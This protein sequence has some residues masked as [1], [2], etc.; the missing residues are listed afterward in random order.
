[1]DKHAIY[2]H[3]GLGGTS[4]I[5]RQCALILVDFVN[6]FVDVDQ[7][8]GPHIQAAADQTVALLAYFR[9]QGLPIVHTRV[10]FSSDGADVNIFALR[11]PPLQ[12][13]TEEANASQIVPQLEPLGGEWVIRKQSA[14]AFFETGLAGWLLQR[15][16]DTAVITG[17][18]T[19]GCVRAS[20]VD[21]MQHNLRTLVISDCVGDR[22]LEP[23]A[24][25]LFDMQQKYADV[26]T[27]DEFITQHQAVK[28]CI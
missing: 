22:A 4:G 23:H 27:R 17:C 13:L 7:L 20:V 19:S 12:K 26:M 14:S 18:T 8:G 5:G 6:G 10:V 3:Q 11:V 24:A 1:M 25:N 28:A 16:V 2:R 21:A 9:A 15:G